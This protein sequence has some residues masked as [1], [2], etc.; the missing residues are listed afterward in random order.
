MYQ[1]AE[2]LGDGCKSAVRQGIPD[3]LRP[4]ICM[5]APMPGRGFRQLVPEV[6]RWWFTPERSQIL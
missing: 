1:P 3:G 6:S 2:H 4:V 5:G